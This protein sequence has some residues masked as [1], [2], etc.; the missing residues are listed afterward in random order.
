MAKVEGGGVE[1][2]RM[3]LSNDICVSLDIMTRLQHYIVL[4]FYIFTKQA[5]FALYC[6]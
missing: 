6:L 3:F 5:T 2:D 1:P 4:N